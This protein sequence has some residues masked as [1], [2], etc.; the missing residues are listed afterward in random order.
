MISGLLKTIRHDGHTHN[1]PTALNDTVS[2]STQPHTP[3]NA[4]TAN[5][6]P[7]PPQRQPDHDTTL[8][9]TPS[10]SHYGFP[11][12]PHH[13]PKE[14]NKPPS[15]PTPLRK[16]TKPPRYQFK[17]ASQTHL[18]TTTIS[19]ALP[20]FHVCQMLEEA[21]YILGPVFNWG[22]T[23][24]SNVDAPLAGYSWDYLSYLLL[25]CTISVIVPIVSLLKFIPHEE[26]LYP[27][28]K[29]DEKMEMVMPPYEMGMM[30]E[31]MQGN[32]M[33]P[34]YSGMDIGIDSD[35]DT[36][37]GIHHGYPVPHTHDSQHHSDEH[38]QHSYVV[39]PIHDIEH[40]DGDLIESY[41]VPQRQHSDED[42][43]YSYPSPPSPILQRSGEIIKPSQHVHPIRIS[44]HSRENSH[45]GHKFFPNY[46]LRSRNHRRSNR[47]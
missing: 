41:F 29:E 10:H 15:L 12:P 19:P 14:V 17:E 45:Q 25:Y 13:P 23:T 26:L 34:L 30:V 20:T 36:Q 5:H 7:L 43:H 35:E 46:I 33:N 4:T 37:Q 1:H 8:H 16:Y 32:G 39:Q 2:R 21:R 24:N 38:P 40:S 6:P 27:K 9:S 47:K 3:V 18:T 28:K 22:P 44:R 11:N 31:A 42:L